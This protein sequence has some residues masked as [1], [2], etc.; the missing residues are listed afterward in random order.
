MFQ[1][2]LFR[3]CR[4]CYSAVLDPG[5]IVATSDGQIAV[6]GRVV[7][8]S[9]QAVARQKDKYQGCFFLV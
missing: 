2:S 7:P 1:S 9:A 6:G 5:L 4:C 8:L 3:N